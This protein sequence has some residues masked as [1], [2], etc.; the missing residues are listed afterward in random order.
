MV[1]GFFYDYFSWIMFLVIILNIQQRKYR[2]S[3]QKRR[4]TLLLAV[5]WLCIYVLLIMRNSFALPEWTEWVCVAIG[6]LVIVIFNKIFWPFRLHCRECG[7]NLTFDRILGGDDNLCT[8]C[9]YKKYPEEKE[10][11]EKK[12]KAKKKDIPKTEEDWDA[13]FRAADRV[14]QID[15]ANWEPTERCTLTYVTDG[16]RI[17]LIEK[18]TGMGSGYLNAP[19]GHIELEETKTEAAVRETKEETGLDVSDLEER[20]TLYFQFKEG[21]RMIGYV[22][23]TST[24]SGT[25]IDECEETR[26]FWTNISSLDYSKMWEDD[27]LWLPLALE[28]KHFDAYFIFDDRKMLDSKVE[29][30]ED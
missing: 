2:H 29:E 14:D 19:G 18:K 5:D 8:D 28:G 3:M 13:E 1:L 16:D 12:A 24:Y 7:R 22:F 30:R 23:F 27:C 26:P 9:Y 6:L 15:W 17:L 4:A 21:I 25:L 11:A 10:E 20:G